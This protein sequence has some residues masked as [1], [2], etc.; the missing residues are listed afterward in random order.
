MCWPWPFA[1]IY[2]PPS[3]TNYA[4]ILLIDDDQTLRR[5]LRLSLEQSGYTVTDAEDGG[6]GLRAFA[7]QPAELVITD[8]IM[9][10]VE[11]ME[12]IRELRKLS[13]AVP[14]IAISGGGRITSD[15]Y[16]HMAKLLGA[17]AIL[18]KPFD[19]EVLRGAVARL[20][21][22]AATAKR[23]LPLES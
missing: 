14:V 10:D 8:I 23:P 9:P 21:A 4:R 11:G 12:T 20:L 3:P 6:Q 5:A 18:A 15:D 13:P 2:R 1:V 7:A 19:I 17:S 16:L 22:P